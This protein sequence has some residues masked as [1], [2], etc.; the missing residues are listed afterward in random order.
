MA[1]EESRLFN[2]AEA[3]GETRDLARLHPD[4]VGPLQEAGERY[5]EGVDVIL[6]K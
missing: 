6:A 3:P 4:T 2:V 5:V 1:D